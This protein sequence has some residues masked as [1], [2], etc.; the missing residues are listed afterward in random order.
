MRPPDLNAM[1]LPDLFEH[2][3]EMGRLERWFSIVREEDLGPEGLD[4]TSRAC[5]QGSERMRA[6]ILARERGVVSGLAALP[7]LFEAFGADIQ[8][9]PAVADG[10]SVEA[11]AAA[12]RLEGRV[13]DVLAVERSML[14]LLGRLSGVATRTDA[15]VRAMGAGHSAALYDTRKTTPGLRHLE[16]YA[17]RCGGGHCHR[18]GLH[19]AVLIKD[20]HIAAARGED[21]A[22]AVARVAAEAR[23]LRGDALRFVMVEVDSLGQ[24][25][26]VLS[27]DEGAVDIVL[28][29]NMSLE[30]L[31]EAAALRD[32]RRPA[33]QLEASGGVRLETV[34][35][36]AL[37]GVD[38]ISAGSLT[39]H[40]VSIDFGLDAE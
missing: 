11:G 25:E 6:G 34:R 29:D 39:H 14:N 23:S 8:M 16:K 5:F 9:E 17:V 40:A 7:R 27:L 3:A 35:E 13:R 21:I 31:R 32:Q 2:L 1:L 33:L 22:D 18:I 36:I 19:D 4:V 37:T 15:F 28:L 26:R 24:L 38:R 20:N 12:A 10:E 30:H